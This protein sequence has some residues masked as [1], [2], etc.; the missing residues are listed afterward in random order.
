MTLED[1]LLDDIRA[2]K[3]VDIER[4]L[5][6]V[7]G[8]DTEEKIA[9]YKT[10]ISLLERRL[11]ECA[12][13]AGNARQI[14][15]S[16]HNL[17][18]QGEGPYLK[19]RKF[20]VP[21]AI[22][23]KLAGKPVGNCT[24]LSASYASLGLRK[25]L[26]V[27]ALIMPGHVALRVMDNGMPID[28]ETTGRYGI[29]GDE[30]RGV[31][32]LPPL[33]IVA[34]LLI[35]RGHAKYHLGDLKGAITDYSKALKISPKDAS[36]LYNRGVAKYDMGNPKGAITDYSKALKI[37]PKYADVLYNRGNAKYDMGNPKGAITDFSRVLKI[38]P[39]DVD[40]LYNRGL[41]REMLGN[42]KGAKA[43][44]EACRKLEARNDA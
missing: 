26:D 12:P 30:H 44:F 6:I 24:I 29:G 14:I 36:A 10:K 40:A 41:A 25:G 1:R 3:Q 39:K 13:T 5:L 28:I 11:D 37:N 4:A 19:A 23:A 20:E 2:G 33:A 42:W 18:W 34:S 16:I 21:D 38:N 31:E 27:H 35:N 32:G 17:F 9:E 8:C 22:D 7:S 43:D 15:T